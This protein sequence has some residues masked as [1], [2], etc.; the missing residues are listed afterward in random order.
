MFDA[1]D[2][3]YDELEDDFVFIANEGMPLLVPDEDQEDGEEDDQDED[4]DDDLGIVGGKKGDKDAKKGI[5][6]N[7][8]AG[9]H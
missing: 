6:K 7:K 2:G 5:L 3:D 8:D 4:E 9:D 1:A